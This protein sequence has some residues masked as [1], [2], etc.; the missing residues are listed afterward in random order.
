MTNIRI[1]RHGETDWNVERRLQGR[2]DI[3]LNENG[4]AQARAIIG[5]IKDLE[6]DVC[7]CSPLRRAKET[8]E[9][10]LDGWGGETVY[11][12]R[13]TERNYGKYEGLFSGK[14]SNDLGLWT[15]GAKFDASVETL[16]SLI[17][18]AKEFLDDITAKYKGK[19]ILIV[20]HSGIIK[21]LCAYFDGVPVSDN[22]YD[23]K[24]IGNCEVLNYRV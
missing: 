6:I 4:R 23:I 14:T 10:I 5:A 19:N 13:I 22:I 12:Q 7:I 16:D 15:L 9:I 18:R 17:K 1:V 3:P 11:D 8:A 20:S 2:S 24:S 21:A